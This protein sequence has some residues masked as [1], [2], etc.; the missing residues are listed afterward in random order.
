MTK[1]AVVNPVYFETHFRSPQPVT[2]WPSE[3]VIVTAYATT[4]ERWTSASAAR[5]R[6]AKAARMEMT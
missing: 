3:F 4:G 2:D 1:P 6:P 5:P